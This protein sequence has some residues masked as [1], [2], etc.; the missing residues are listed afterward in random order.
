[1][2]VYDEEETHMSDPRTC[3]LCRHWDIFFEG[4]YSD[5]TPGSGFYSR[6][7]KSHWSIYGYELSR[8]AY[9]EKILTANN[10]NDYEE[11]NNG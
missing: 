6:C 1:M 3:I 5:Q 4:D 9:R 10:C 8:K 11:V 2:P 7:M